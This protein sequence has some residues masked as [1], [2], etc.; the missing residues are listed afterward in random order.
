MKTLSK[1]DAG[2]GF[3]PAHKL[4]AL[5]RDREVGSLELLEHYLA[6]VKKYNPALNA[7]ILLQEERARAAARK[8]DESLARGAPPGPLHGVPISI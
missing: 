8:A 1:I 6:R 7:I 2:L 4:A 5:V 3:E